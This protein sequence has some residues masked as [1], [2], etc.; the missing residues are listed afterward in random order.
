M[1]RNSA[2]ILSWVRALMCSKTEHDTMRSAE[3]FGDTSVRCQVRQ[4]EVFDHLRNRAFLNLQAI[5][6][7]SPELC[8]HLIAAPTDKLN[9]RSDQAAINR[10]RRRSRS[11]S[12][13]VSVT[14]AAPAARNVIAAI[15]CQPD[16]ISKI[17]FL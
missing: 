8:D 15:G 9:C 4:T 17:R 6:V 7:C 2:I 13:S 14:L 10:I 11:S 1:R 5:K 16:P 12:I 3:A